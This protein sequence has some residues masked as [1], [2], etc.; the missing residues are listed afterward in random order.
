LKETKKQ[1]SAFSAVLQKSTNKLWGCH[2]VVQNNIVQQF[3]E[4]NSRR[5]VC[6]LNDEVEYQTALL[7]Y[8]DGTFVVR[9]NKPTQK[10]FGW[11][12]GDEVNVQLR[13]DES[14]YGLAMPGEF[15]ELL[16]QDEDGNR[17]FQSLTDGKKRTLLY[18]IGSKKNPDARIHHAVTVINHLKANR[19]MINFRQLYDAVKRKP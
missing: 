2:F 8:G 17:L 4:V 15:E 10:K 18:F 3:D 6:S 7:P 12:I 1:T 16:R 11:K 14:K 9:V 5:V 13:K 19:G